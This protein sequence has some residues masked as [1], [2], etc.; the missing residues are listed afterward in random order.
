MTSSVSGL[1]RSSK[2]LPKAKLAPKKRHGHCLMV[3][4]QSDPLN[5]SESG[6]NHYIW[7]VCS[8]HQRNALESPT[9]AAGTGQQ[10]G[11][12]SSPQ[13]TLQKLND[14]A[15]RVLPHPPCSKFKAQSCLTLCDPKDCSS[16][17]SSVHGILQARILEWVAISF[18]RASSRPRDRTRVSRIA[19]RLFTIWATREAHIHLTSHQL[20]TFSSISTTFCREHASTILRMQK[21]ASQEFVAS[22]NTDFYT[23]GIN[24]RFSLAKMC[25]L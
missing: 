10:K 12:N 4:C 22:W 23:T 21:N 14:L 9:P 18:S 6:R 24:E 17:G 15:Y 25:L 16:P 1:R 7:E 11:P 8:A 2:A 3:C 19:G 20:T 5:F 13:S